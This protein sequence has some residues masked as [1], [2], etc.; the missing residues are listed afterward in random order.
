MAESFMSFL[1]WKLAGELCPR[2]RRRGR[3]AWLLVS[4]RDGCPSGERVAASAPKQTGRRGVRPAKNPWA[5]RIGCLQCDYEST[6]KRRLCHWENY[7]R[8]NRDGKG[9]GPQWEKY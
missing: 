6:V 7:A 5:F 1:F 2:P 3:F 4:G 9:C 8:Q